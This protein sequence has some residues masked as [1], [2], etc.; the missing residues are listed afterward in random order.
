[1]DN[2]IKYIS[3]KENSGTDNKQLVCITKKGKRIV[4]EFTWELLTEE[5]FQNLNKNSSPD[6]FYKAIEK[7]LKRELD[8]DDLKDI[9]LINTD[10]YHRYCL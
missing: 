10:N 4:F 6:D 8:K 3:I 1:M 5:N 2:R 7:F 9:Y